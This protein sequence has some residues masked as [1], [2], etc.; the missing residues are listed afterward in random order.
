[1]KT[2]LAVYTGS[3][4]GMEAWNT[5]DAAQRQAEEETAWKAWAEKQQVATGV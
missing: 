5:L 3:P 1:M 4:A 2:F